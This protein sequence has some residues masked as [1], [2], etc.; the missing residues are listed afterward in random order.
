MSKQSDVL[1]TGQPTSASGQYVFVGPRGGRI[2]PEVTSIGSKPLPLPPESGQGYM[3]V[4]QTMRETTFEVRVPTELLKYGYQAQDIER[5]F[6]EWLV[7]SLF[8][9]QH[10]SSGKA[11]RL[12]GITRLEFLSLLRWH[13]IAYV[14]YSE[15][16]LADELAAVDSLEIERLL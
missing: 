2:G 16:E 8:K 7:L 6:T 5:Q 15:D 11:A 13:G 4:D 3:L 12:L 1:R 9:D 10:I 14:D